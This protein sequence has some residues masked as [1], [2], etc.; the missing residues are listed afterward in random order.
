M[1]SA[2]NDASPGVSDPSS[3]SGS[4][5]SWVLRGGAGPPTTRP[6]PRRWPRHTSNDPGGVSADHAGVGHE[7]W[8]TWRTSCRGG[9]P[10]RRE[11]AGPPARP[12]R[13]ER[14][15]RHGSGGERAIADQ[16]GLD[17][18]APARSGR[19]AAALAVLPTLTEVSRA[20]LLCGGL[21]TGGQDVESGDM[22][23]WPERGLTGREAVPQETSGF[24]PARVAVADD[25]AAAIEDVSGAPLV[26]C[27]LNTIDD[28]LDRS[29]PGGTAWTADAV[30][31]LAPLL[32]RARHAG[33]VV[34]LTADHG[35]VVERRQGAQRAYADDL[36]RPV[37]GGDRPWGDGEML[38]AGRR[39]CSTTA[40]R[41]GRRRAAA[42]RAV[43]SRLPRRRG[44]GRSRR[45]R[46]R[47]RLW[48]GP[49]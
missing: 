25:V 42:V 37:A 22:S 24:V 45:A 49:R 46:G 4:P 34:V 19:R 38:V 3:A 48:R 13:D 40:G 30:R 41:A 35:H 32:D 31:H 43:E 6:S 17:R 10:D 14:R 21:C 5:L 16:R 7:V 1:D 2:V 11:N 28:A 29:D 15:G 26:T 44:A 20:S 8:H 27:V 33:R 18:G 47:S 36:Q 39:V 12:R 9:D 23:G